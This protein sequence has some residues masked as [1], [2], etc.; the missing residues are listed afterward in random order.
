MRRRIWAGGFAALLAGS[1]SL[2]QEVEF[3]RDI[4]PILS[5]KCYTCHGPNKASRQTKLRF[6]AED[7]AKQ[8]LGGHFAIVPGD[9]EK[10]AMVQRITA[11][12]PAMRMPPVRSGYKL[13]DG[14]ISLIRRWIE[15]GAKWEKHWSFIPP[16]RRAAAGGPRPRVA[17]KPDRQFRPGAPGA[18]R[19][20][21]V[22]RGGSRAPDPARHARPDR[23]AADARGGRRLSRGQ[24]SR[25]LRE[26]GGPPARLAALRR[27]HGACAGSTRRATPTPTATRPTASASMWRWRD[28]V[29]DAFNRNMPFDRFTIEQTR[30]RPA[31]QRH[32]STRRSPPA[33]TA[34]T[35]ATPRA[36][37][38][39]RSTRVEYVVDRVDT[40]ATVWLGL[41]LGCA[42]CHDH[43]YDPF[44]QKEFYQVFA[45]FN[46]V[47]EKG[48][49][50]KYGNSPPVI[51]APTRGAA[52]GTE[53]SR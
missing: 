7:G 13:T 31:A 42:R 53:G 50:L 28:W 41:T 43:K 39:R 47:P 49:A 38:F 14:E 51:Q 8:D 19:A 25:R 52:G 40:T 36:A 48:N 45:Y 34:T 12:K 44:T 23:P 4:R 17:A 27:A 29:I 20:E 32:A 11:S 5:D 6:D 26:G 3:N 22:A 10:S 2:A 16:K 21:A 24:I 35:A 37:S 9:A 30:R 1:V 33:S 15:Q 46:N 18:G